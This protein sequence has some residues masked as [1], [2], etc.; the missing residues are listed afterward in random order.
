M[1]ERTLS[2]SAPILIVGAGVFGLSTALHLGKRGYKNVTVLDKQL[3]D[4]TLYAYDKGCDA[5][6]AGMNILPN[7]MGS[8]LADL[9]SQI[10]IKS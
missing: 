1:N 4:K 9:N 10:S 2:K 7:H 6:S 5:A 3:Y 8:K